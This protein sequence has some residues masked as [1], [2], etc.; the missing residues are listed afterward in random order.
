MFMKPEKITKH[1][2]V[3]IRYKGTKKEHK[4]PPKTTIVRKEYIHI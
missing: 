2:N 4:F 3:Q 1:D